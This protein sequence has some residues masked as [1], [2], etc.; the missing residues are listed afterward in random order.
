VARRGALL[1]TLADEIAAAGRE[2]PLTIVQDLTAAGAPQA[3]HDAVRAQF[4]HLDILVNNAGGSRPLEGLGSDAQWAEA[5]ALNFDAARRLT[6]V[7]VDAMRTRGFG[8]I[9]NVTGT[10]EP[11]ILNAAMPPN[12]AMHIWAKALSRVVARD[13]VT[14]NSIPP[15]RIHSEQIDTRILPTREAQERWAAAHCPAGYVGEPEDLAVLVA[16]LCSPRARYITGQVI[17]VDGGV[18]LVAH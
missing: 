8:R 1:D 10:D 4:G 17:H 12:G 15:G 18:R 2:R 13:G 16:F 5:M 14:V 7:F 3:I 6:H 11:L 9:V